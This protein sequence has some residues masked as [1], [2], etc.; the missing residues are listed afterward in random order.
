MTTPFILGAIGVWVLCGI[1]TGLVMRRRGHD[2]MSWT[3]VGAVLGP[4]VIPLAV[5]RSRLEPSTSVV[6]RVGEHSTGPLDVLVG[7]DGSDDARRAF[8]T[9]M[10][11]FGATASSITI[12]TVVDF[13]VVDSTMTDDLVAEAEA[14]LADVAASAGRADI[15]TKVLYGKPTTAIADFASTTGKEVIVIGPR[16]RGAAKALFGSVATGLADGCAVP[17][18]VGTS[19]PEHARPYMSPD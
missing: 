12:A 4:F 5:E 17:V 7:L 1:T 3:L 10:T 16:G 9:A 6:P 14:M 15:R 2:L 18:L 8:D 13:D 11:L 19:Q